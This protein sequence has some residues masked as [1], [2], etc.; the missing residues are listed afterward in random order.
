MRIRGQFFGYS[1]VIGGLIFAYHGNGKGSLTY[2]R[3]LLDELYDGTEVR[4]M[5]YTARYETYDMVYMMR[6]FATRSALV[7]LFL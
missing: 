7:L 4:V 2:T 3:E 5:R 1:F 6:V